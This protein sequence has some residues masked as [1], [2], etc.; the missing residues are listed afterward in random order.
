[1]NNGFPEIQLY[2]GG[3]SGDRYVFPRQETISAENLKQ[4]VRRHSRVYVNLAGC[5]RELDQLAERFA[6]READEK[7]GGKE[8]LAEVEKLIAQNESENKVRYFKLKSQK[9]KN[10]RTHLVC[11]SFRQTWPM[12]D[13]FI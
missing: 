3:A 4:F 11:T 6:L 5:V 7:N 12:R 9:L 1:M 10:N 2:V 13:A 8:Q